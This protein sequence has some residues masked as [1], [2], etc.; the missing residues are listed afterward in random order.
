MMD[1]LVFCCS[2][3][4]RLEIAMASTL[5]QSIC[6]RYRRRHAFILYIVAYLILLSFCQ[7]AQI[8]AKSQLCEVETGQTNII[9]DI[10]ESKGDCKYSIWAQWWDSGRECTILAF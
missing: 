5:Q 8:A 9:L 6:I 1:V 2:Y 7:H 3:F 10:E 4:E